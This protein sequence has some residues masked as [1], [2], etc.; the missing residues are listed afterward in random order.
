VETVT[1]WASELGCRVSELEYLMF[2][3]AATSDATSQ[4]SEPAFARADEASPISASSLTPEETAVL[5]ALDDATDAF[6]ALPQS[7]TAA[8]SD[9]FERAIR[10]LRRIILARCST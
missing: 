8:D 2:A 3:A 7:A 1:A 4:W 6:A 9:D 10:Q 5:E